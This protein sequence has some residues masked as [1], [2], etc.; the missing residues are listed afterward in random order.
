MM[1]KII[2]PF[3]IISLIS[4]A[5]CGNQDEELIFICKQELD[6][7]YI[8]LGKPAGRDKATLEKIRKEA[9]LQISAIALSGKE[10]LSIATAVAEDHILILIGENLEMNTRVEWRPPN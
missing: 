3:L 2:I 8:S 1:A 5:G 9:Q 4:I 7:A 10:G 6:A